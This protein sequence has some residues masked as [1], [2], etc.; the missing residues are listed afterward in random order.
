MPTIKELAKVVE[1][2]SPPAK[3]SAFILLSTVHKKLDDPISA[4]KTVMIKSD[5]TS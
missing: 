3:C 1:R 4:I 5:S 2:E